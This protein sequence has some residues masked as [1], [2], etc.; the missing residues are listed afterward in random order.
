MTF[1]DATVAGVASA[2]LRGSASPGT[3][4]YELHVVAVAR[5]GGLGRGGG[6][7]RGVE[8]TPYGTEAMHVLRAEKGS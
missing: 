5:A 4:S 3:W 2:D 7:G 1:R 6:G 8:I